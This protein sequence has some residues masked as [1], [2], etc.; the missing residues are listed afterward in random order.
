[1]ILKASHSP[2]ARIRSRKLIM[3]QPDTICQSVKILLCL[4]WISRPNRKN[5]CSGNGVKLS[6][7][8][9][10]KYVHRFAVPWELGLCWPLTVR[11]TGVCGRGRLWDA[12][13]PAA[14]FPVVV[15]CVLAT[16]RSRPRRQ[17]PAPGASPGARQQCQRSRQREVPSR[18]HT[19][20][21]PPDYHI[22]DRDWP[23][24]LRGGERRSSGSAAHQRA[25]S[26]IRLN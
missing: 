1:M 19:T 21:L 24:T 6:L 5:T 13:P 22:L 18:F 9:V 7:R 2:R 10:K 12:V 11:L 26:R 3:R 23:G 17:S 25:C 15:L 4:F 14:T 20:R 8:Q 16:G